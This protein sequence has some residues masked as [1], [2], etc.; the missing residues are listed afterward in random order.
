VGNEKRE[1]VYEVPFPGKT[2][3]DKSFVEDLW[4][5]RKVG[6][7][8][9]QVRS[10]GEN[11]EVVAE[12]IRLAKHHGIATPYTSYLVVPDS[13]V[14]RDQNEY[15]FWSELP[16]PNA[17]M[18]PR[19]FVD[20]DGTAVPSSAAGG[21]GGGGAGRIQFAPVFVSPN[22]Q[23]AI[24]KSFL[25]NGLTPPAATPVNSSPPSPGY[26]TNQNCVDALPG[27][28]RPLPTAG[29]QG[30]DLSL[31]VNELRNQSQ[32]SV[33]T[34]REA[35]GRRCRQVNGGWI[36]TAF[37]SKTPT[38]KVKALSDAYFRLLERQPQLRNVFQLGNSLVWITPS[39]TALV[40][41]P[42]E[43]S[44]RLSDAEIDGLFKKKYNVG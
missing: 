2:K 8:L 43:G 44:E 22:M 38:V 13:T 23:W 16:A 41:A 30:V 12:V 1:F 39:G 35:A 42:A 9:D 31:Q 5:R 3:K 4:A 11:K 26:Y 7:L 37:D 18:P 34:V 25:T 32:V 27:V 19:G 40:I 6:Y 24:P 20:T 10:H 14:A 21:A 36:D 15:R 33:T 29:K 17:P 28:P